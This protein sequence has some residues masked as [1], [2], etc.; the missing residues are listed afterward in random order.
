MYILLIILIFARAFAQDEPRCN[1]RI[2]E[3]GN[4]TL[5]AGEQF[6]NVT[7]NTVPG[8]FGLFDTVSYDVKD[9]IRASGSFT[10]KEQVFLA[11]GTA[12]FNEFNSAYKL[13]IDNGIFSFSVVRSYD[14]IN[15]VPGLPSRAVIDAK[16][17]TPAPDLLMGAGLVLVTDGFYVGYLGETFG[18][19]YQSNGMV[20]IFELQITVNGVGDV[21]IGTPAGPVTVTL[22]GSVEESASLIAIAVRAASSQYQYYAVGDTVYVVG[23]NTQFSLG[24]ITYNPL[25]TGSTGVVTQTQILRLKDEVVVGEFVNDVSWL[26]PQLFNIYQLDYGKTVMGMKASVYNPELRKFQPLCRIDTANSRTSPQFNYANFKVGWT[27]ASLGSSVEKSIEGSSAALGYMEGSAS[28]FS[29]GSLYFQ[30]GE[31]VSG[32]PVATPTYFFTIQVSRLLSGSQIFGYLAL[33]VGTFT[34]ISTRGAEF[35]IYKNCDLIGTPEFTFIDEANSIALKDTQ[36]TGCT[37]GQ[38][39]AKYS[40]GR[41]ATITPNFEDINLKINIGETLTFIGNSIINSNDASIDVNWEERF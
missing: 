31:I 11:G 36:A 2:T 12:G 22:G 14:Y 29:S 32:L 5:G 16:F 35:F 19:V 1:V 38:L 33:K 8:Q 13:G 27:L 20:E 6:L 3:W 23:T 34:T 21:E 37:G 7:T 41:Y 39:V 24:G 4:T 26:N 30:T 17:D 15:D 18:C 9:F 28:S 40:L 10:L 25:A